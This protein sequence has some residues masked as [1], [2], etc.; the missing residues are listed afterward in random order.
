MRVLMKVTLATEEFNTAARKGT[1]GK[2]M[3]R[4]LDAQKP[5]AAYWTE[6]NGKRTG[7]L[8]VDLAD[9][10]EIPALCEPWFLTFKADVEIHPVMTSQDLGKGGLDALGKKWA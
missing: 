7:L 1:A 3:K 5:E 10:T 2:K 8:I 4:I 6:F 9:A